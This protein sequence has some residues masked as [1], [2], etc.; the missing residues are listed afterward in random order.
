M[1]NITPRWLSLK[2]ASSYVQVSP[3]TLISW[4]DSGALGRGIV[5][6]I[7]KRQPSGRGRHVATVRIDRMALDR[8]LEARA[9]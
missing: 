8:F 9:R 4:A 2:S 6:R 5:V 1:A 7:R 3:K